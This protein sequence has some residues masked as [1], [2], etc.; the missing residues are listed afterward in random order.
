MVS[1]SHGNYLFESRNLTI[2]LHHRVQPALLGMA[3]NLPTRHIILTP[4]DTAPP[5]NTKTAQ[6][7][8]FKQCVIFRRD[9]IIQIKK[10][11]AIVQDEK[12]AINEKI[13]NLYN[14]FSGIDSP[15]GRL[16]GG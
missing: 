1:S 13:T 15:V 3:H 5:G 10:Y 8:R 7:S 11:H 16:V 14:V 9:L 2:E 6:N 12:K 4:Q